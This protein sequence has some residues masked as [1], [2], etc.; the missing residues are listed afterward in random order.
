MSNNFKSINLWIIRIG[1]FIVPLIPL[2]VSSSLFFPFIT[3]KAFIFR[4]IIEIVFLSWVILAVN[5]GE[6]RPKRTYLFWAL[7]AFIVAITLATVFGANPEKSF[8]SNYERMEGLVT[9]LHLFAYFLVLCR[10]PGTP[11]TIGAQRACAEDK[12]G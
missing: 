12:R 1:L 9:H 8:W 2:Y 10:A 6:F 4:T 11:E 7:V 5:F 3:G